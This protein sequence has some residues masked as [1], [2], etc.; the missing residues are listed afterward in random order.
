MKI[1]LLKNK[2]F[3]KANEKEMAL[4]YGL[5]IQEDDY[6]C[7]AKYR[8]DNNDIESFIEFANKVGVSVLYYDV[9]A[10]KEKLVGLMVYFK[11]NEEYHKFSWFDDSVYI[12][13]ISKNEKKE[14]NYTIFN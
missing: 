1:D 13:T 5:P 8:W 6:F 3:E 4:F 2:F 12:K 11:F 9:L 14:K 10:N 7:H